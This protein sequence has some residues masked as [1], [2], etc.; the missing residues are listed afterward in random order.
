MSQSVGEILRPPAAGRL[1]GVFRSGGVGLQSPHRCSVGLVAVVVEELLA[2]ADLPTL[3]S[4]ATM[5]TLA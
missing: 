2:R 3:W 4:P 5:I 1:P